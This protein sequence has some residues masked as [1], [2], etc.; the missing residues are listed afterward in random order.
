M[1]AQATN[2]DLVAI[3]LSQTRTNKLQLMGTKKKLSKN[4]GCAQPVVNEGNNAGAIG[5]MS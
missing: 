1:D 3:V 5:E 2:I 4:A